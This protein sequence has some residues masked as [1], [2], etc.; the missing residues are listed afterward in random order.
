MLA[1]LLKSLF[2]PR[3]SAVNAQLPGT[4]PEANASKH[5][6]LSPQVRRLISEGRLREALEQVESARVGNEP[7]LG[8]LRGWLYFRLG[9]AERSLVALDQAMATDPHD[10]SCWRFAADAYLSAGRHEAALQC[11]QRLLQRNS[12]EAD[13]WCLAGSCHIALAQWRHAV[14]CF[15]S[16]SNSVHPHQAIALQNLGFSFFNLAQYEDARVALQGAVRVDPNL[17]EAHLNLGNTLKKL[18]ELDAALA[19]YRQAL[20]R[21]PENTRYLSEYA[22]AL[23]YTCRWE[24]LKPVVEK[25]GRLTRQEIA[26]GSVPGMAPYVCLTLFDDL[27]LQQ[28]VAAGHTHR[29]PAS[30]RST[31]PPSRRGQRLSVGYLSPDLNRHPVGLLTDGFIGFHDRE[32]IRVNGYYLRE[33]ID[34]TTE[35]ISSKCEQF[36]CLAGYSD[37]AAADQIRQD[38][39]DVL[40]D[41]SGLTAYCRPGILARRPAHVIAHMMGYPGTYGASYVDF[42]I[43][44]AAQVPLEFQS[45]FTERLHHLPETGVAMAGF[46][47]VNPVTRSQLGLPADMFVFANLSS[48]YRICPTVFG[49]W[50]RILSRCPHSVLWLKRENPQAE[51]ELQRQAIS[52]GIDPARLHFTP[53]SLLSQTW[54]HQCAD[55]WLDTFLFT[56]GT[57]TALCYWAEVPVLTLAGSTPQA[58]TGAMMQAGA[59]ISSTVVT[60]IEE[61]EAVAVEIYENTEL[62]RNLRSDLQ[63][64]VRQS[65]LFQ[66]QL[67]AGRL[68]NAY[69]EL[70]DVRP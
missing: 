11:C 64:R 2:R 55:L 24:E 8:Y 32:R 39:N 21:Q 66:P 4:Q 42:Y 22:D 7:D 60:G 41:L 69:V 20:V 5:S 58:R 65:P 57:A 70:L 19:C 25:L 12:A 51:T 62:H 6:G 16:A 26:A 34:S 29:Y 63:H 54:E 40:I 47:T 48:T 31:R 10:P 9:E 59:Q 23:R 36:R 18:G 35:S 52:A 17:A 46:G 37:K 49:C 28:Q 45:A 68:D 1:G 33:V 27:G 56:S 61:Y 15:Q 67:F 13:V 50:M 43:C 14:E 30:A 44:H 3:A 38:R 53:P